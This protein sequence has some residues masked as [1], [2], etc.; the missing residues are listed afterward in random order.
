MLDKNRISSAASRRLPNVVQEGLR[1]DLVF[2]NMGLPADRHGMKHDFDGLRQIN[3]HGRLQIAVARFHGQLGV[4]VVGP[5]LRKA[6]AV[7][8]LQ[9]IEEI[10][11][12]CLSVMRL[13]V[14]PKHRQP[15]QFLLHL[16]GHE[17]PEQE[18]EKKGI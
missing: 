14:V 8:Q 10:E 9:E 17:C 11:V 12:G 4:V 2:K 15:G 18:E 16:T 6:L 13:E 1:K 3:R 7:V 5:M